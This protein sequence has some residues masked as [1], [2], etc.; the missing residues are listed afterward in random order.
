V[1]PEQVAELDE[2]IRA[3]RP[4]MVLFDLGA[5]FGVFS[6]AAAHGGGPRAQI[7]AVE[8]SETACRVLR[9][10]ARLN[11]VTVQVVHAAAGDRPGS[12]T[13]L[14]VGV[15]A[16]GYFVAADAEHPAR[17]TV[18]V[19]TVSIDSLADRLGVD[20]THVK[21]DVEGAEEAVLRG[22]ERTLGGDLAPV[23]FVELHN[24]LVRRRGGAPQATLEVLAKYG[25]HHF[26]EAGQAV[27]KND[28]PSKPLVR[29]V[30]RKGQGA[31][32]AA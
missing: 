28:L 12:T 2:F 27:S 32:P 30:A 26:T 5:H 10:Q 7:V 21:I 24:D 6:L 3:C 25:Y 23:L 4:S 18:R 20:P 13:M 19:P 31:G 17:E 29:V 1:D 11:D 9:I 14:P 22:G 16:D 15:I 8:P